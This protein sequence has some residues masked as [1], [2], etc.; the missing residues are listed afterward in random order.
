[1]DSKP[2]LQVIIPSAA[3]SGALISCILAPTEL[4][5][6]SPAVNLSLSLSLSLVVVSEYI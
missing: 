5:K 1:M 3:C 2:Q 6:V 4:T